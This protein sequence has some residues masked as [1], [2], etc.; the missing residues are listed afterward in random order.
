MRINSDC[1]FTY[2]DN[3][4]KAENGTK[5]LTLGKASTPLVRLQ[6]EDSVSKLKTH[7]PTLSSVVDTRH[8]THQNSLCDLHRKCVRHGHVRCGFRHHNPISQ[9]QI[10]SQEIETQ[11]FQLNPF[12]I[13]G[14]EGGEAGAYGQQTVPAEVWMFVWQESQELAPRG[15]QLIGGPP[16]QVEH[17]AVQNSHVLPAWRPTNNSYLLYLNQKFFWYLISKTTLT[18]TFSNKKYPK[19]GI[20]V[21][22]KN[23][24]KMPK[25]T[26]PS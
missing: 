25:E 6:W 26:S 20:F 17:K 11:L 15:E 22:L 21:S 2:V 7:T 4:P 18:S 19:T 9:L 3:I 10:L 8:I 23:N 14:K 5:L 1:W 16:A 12:V 13:A 24:I